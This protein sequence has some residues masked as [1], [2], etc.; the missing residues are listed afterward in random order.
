MFGRTASKST[1][2]NCLTTA[3]HSCP[4]KHCDSHSH[5]ISLIVRGVVNFVLV[6]VD[7]IRL[8]L[9]CHEYQ[10]YFWANL[11]KWVAKLNRSTANC[12]ISDDH[13]GW[14]DRVQRISG[15]IS[16][17]LNMSMHICATEHVLFLGSRPFCYSSSWDCSICQDH[18]GHMVESYIEELIC[19]F[20]AIGFGDLCISVSSKPGDSNKV[21]PVDNQRMLRSSQIRQS[22]MQVVVVQRY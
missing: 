8:F 16:V 1:H 14:L 17:L 6:I 12:H 11:Q 10:R 2:H 20:Q 3:I 4:T 22:D 21:T 9:C 15:S 18:Y 5:I 13:G 7:E 19:C